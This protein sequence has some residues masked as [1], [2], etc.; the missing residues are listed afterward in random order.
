MGRLNVSTT[1]VPVAMTLLTG[2]AKL[3]VPMT[4]VV[5]VRTVKL[6]GKAVVELRAVAPM[7]IV[8]V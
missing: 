5:P 7:V 1:V 3:A 8:N 4:A 6:A 2:T